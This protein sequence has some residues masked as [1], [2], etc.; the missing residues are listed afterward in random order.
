MSTRTESFDA[1]ELGAF[2]ES[3]LGAR[4]GGRKKVLW[5]SPTGVSSRFVVSGDA[6]ENFWGGLGFAYKTTGDDNVDAKNAALIFWS[7][8]LYQMEIP[9]WFRVTQR[10]GRPR[11]VVVFDLLTNAASPVHSLLGLVYGSVTSTG[12]YGPLNPATIDYFQRG[13]SNQL[14]AGQDRLAAPREQHLSFVGGGSPLYAGVD[15]DGY[16]HPVMVQGSEEDMV[17]VVAY[18]GAAI[19]GSHGSGFYNLFLDDNG[20]FLRNLAEA[21][22]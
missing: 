3:R 19:F 13:A 16:H 7:P 1:S 14:T 17:H 8:P 6:V 21:P 12:V 18:G 20:T 11:V 5:V 9:T 4:N 22:T 15:P 2:T 10:T